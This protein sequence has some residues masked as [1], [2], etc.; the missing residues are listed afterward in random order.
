MKKTQVERALDFSKKAGIFRLS[1]AID[2]GI[3]QQTIQR[4]SKRGL[5][6]REGRGLY[7]MPDREIDIFYSLVEAQKRVPI[8]IICLIS[9]LSFYEIGTQLPGEIWMALEK[10]RKP[11]KIEYPPIRF[12]HF[13]GES[14][15][16]G[17][18]N[19][20]IKGI[21]INITNPAKTIADCFKFRNKIGLDVA[22]EALRGCLKNKKCT[23]DELLHY[24]RICRIEKVIQPYIEVIL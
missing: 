18:N 4:L 5:I 17:I 16:A 13:S 8:G 24:S 20:R 10:G 7:T 9:A 6:N 3:H 22:I 2:H 1:E 11:P 23:V 12:V 19:E 15:S 14:I 21:R